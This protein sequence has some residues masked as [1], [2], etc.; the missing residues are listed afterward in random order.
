MVDFKSSHM[1]CVVVRNAAAKLSFSTFPLT[2]SPLMYKFWKKILLHSGVGVGVGVFEGVGVLEGVGVR[3]GVAVLE[4]VG[5]GPAAVAGSPIT[6]A[7]R[8]C[9]TIP[10]RFAVRWS[11]GHIELTSGVISG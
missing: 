2:S 4:G 3:L 10:S 7:V 1:K 11:L 8:N 5:E 9:S 6:R